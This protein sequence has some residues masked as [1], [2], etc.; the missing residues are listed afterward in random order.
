[1][2]NSTDWLDKVMTDTVAAGTVEFGVVFDESLQADTASKVDNSKR[3]KRVGFIRA[4][5]VR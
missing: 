2:L 5:P 3:Q 1:M 4:V